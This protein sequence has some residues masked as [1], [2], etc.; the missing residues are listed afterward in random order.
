MTRDRTIR[1]W[2]LPELIAT[3]AAAVA[4]IASAIAA[5]LVFQLETKSEQRTLTMTTINSLL[6]HREDI[7]ESEVGQVCLLSYS[8]LPTDVM[9]AVNRLKGLDEAFKCD[10]GWCDWYRRCI[11]KES[12]EIADGSQVSLS[13]SE[14]WRMGI[15]ID[16]TMQSYYRLGLLYS[17]NVVD[18][19]LFKDFLKL[20]LRWRSPVVKYMLAA[21]KTY[22]VEEQYDCLTRLIAEINVGS[23]DVPPDWREFC[24]GE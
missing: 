4:A 20:E 5:F 12:A 6:Q 21:S 10:V 1:K 9:L 19:E 7:S 23:E 16:N 11:G 17:E 22:A 13:D 14:A 3:S 18:R 2:R 24:T 15:E 8:T